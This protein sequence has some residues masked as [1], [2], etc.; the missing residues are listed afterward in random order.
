VIVGQGD[1]DVDELDVDSTW[2]C[3]VPRQQLDDFIA[4]GEAA[5]V[6]LD[7]DVGV[8]VLAQHGQPGNSL[9][10]TLGQRK[11]Q[12]FGEV[13]EMPADVSFVARPIAIADPGQHDR[14]QDARDDGAGI[15]AFGVG[16]IQS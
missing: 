9:F 12:R 6:E 14:Q 13:A 8:E 3:L 11:R 2:R 15:A 10:G 16:H 5:I 7:A 4:R 1:G